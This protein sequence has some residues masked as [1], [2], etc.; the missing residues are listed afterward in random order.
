MGLPSGHLS[1]VAMALVTFVLLPL[2]DEPSMIQTLTDV[3]TCV[4]SQVNALSTDNVYFKQCN[5]D[6]S[7]VFVSVVAV[8]EWNSK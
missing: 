3:P 8:T 1:L 6:F 2:G 4:H 7:K 5:S